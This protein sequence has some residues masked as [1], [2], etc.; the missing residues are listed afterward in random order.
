MLALAIIQ[1]AD[2]GDECDG[3]GQKADYLAL[4][5]C[6]VI[7]MSRRVTAR[8]FN[9]AVW[10]AEHWREDGEELVSVRR[11]DAGVD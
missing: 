11:A 6:G 10:Q 5:K 7:H 9:D 2:P 3:E 8:D 1:D 4:Y